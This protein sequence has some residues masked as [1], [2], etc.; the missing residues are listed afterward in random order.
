M[1]CLPENVVKDAQ[2]RIINERYNENNWNTSNESQKFQLTLIK[3][4]ICRKEMKDPQP[5][6]PMG[7]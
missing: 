3:V 4:N 7:S 6:N 1:A 5:S 2:S